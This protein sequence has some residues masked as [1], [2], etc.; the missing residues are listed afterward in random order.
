MLAGM[1]ADPKNE[2][3]I[4]GVGMMLGSVSVFAVMDSL[5]KWLAADYPIYQIM[6]F[7]SAVAV[8]PISL[9]IMV[10]GGWRVLKTAHP[11]L[12]VLRCC[13]GVS[14]MFTAFTGI[15]KM[16]LADAMAIFHSAPILM[17]ALSVPLLK[18]VVGVRRWA[19][20]FIGFCGV[21]L[22]V[23]PGTEVFSQGA[24][25][26]V[27]AAF[28][29]AFASNLVRIMGRFDDPACITFYFTVA[30][31]VVSSIMSLLWG[32][33]T[34][35]LKDTLLLASVGV[36]GGCGQY[37]MTLSLKNAEVG[38]VSPLKYL[39]IVFGG[40]LGFFIWDE[41]PDTF[42]LIGIV[43][44]IGSGV[45]TMQREARLKR[46]QKEKTKEEAKSDFQE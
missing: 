37:F 33:Q 3:P 11:R 32:W 2:R 43:I 10:A 36:L 13:I 41:V 26:M 44:I 15:S 25:Y 34:P 18:E 8:L 46:Q 20:V 24:L 27:V 45:Y 19:A 17:T 38:L 16:P 28:F 42:S 21:L 5:V 40:I 35:S 12:H 30:A 31:T 39:M 22:V 9:F 14:A 29:V 23:K 6:F 7:R 4:F 1:T